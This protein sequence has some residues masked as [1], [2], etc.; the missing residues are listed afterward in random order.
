MSTEPDWEKYRIDPTFDMPGP[1]MVKLLG[2][3]T[4]FIDWRKNVVEE[5]PRENP[6]KKSRR[7]KT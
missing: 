4:A 5:Q 2:F 1:S 7:K 3:M 6:K